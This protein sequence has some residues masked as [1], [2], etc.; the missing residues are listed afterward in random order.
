MS[1]REETKAQKVGRLVPVQGANGRGGVGIWFYGTS[2]PA[3]GCSVLQQ[4]DVRAEPARS[5][6][7]GKTMSLENKTYVRPEVKSA[8]LSILLSDNA[9]ASS[10][11][12]GPQGAGGKQAGELA[13]CRLLKSQVFTV[14]FII[15]T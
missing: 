10:G 8:V 12:E 1:E 14:R 5:F 13:A 6:L 9:A 4:E 3:L 11:T 7:P 2:G 15:L